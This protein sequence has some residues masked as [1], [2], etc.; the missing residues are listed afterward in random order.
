MNSTCPVPDLLPYQAQSTVGPLVLLAHR[1]LS[2]AHRT[3]R[4]DQLIV[5]GGH[6]SPADCAADRW[7][8]A[9]LTHRTVRCTPNSSVIFSRGAFAFPES[10]EFI[11]GPAWAPDTVRCTTGQ[12][13]APQ[14]GAGLAELSQNFFNLFPL[15]LAVSLALREIC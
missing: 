5:G 13:G 6:A 12:S 14:A 1:T 8:W 2:G 9:P 10:D 7:P 11:V 4:C 3:V 15:F